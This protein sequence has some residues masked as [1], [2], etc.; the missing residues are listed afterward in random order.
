MDEK[1]RFTTSEGAALTIVETIVESEEVLVVGGDWLLAYG[2]A[3]QMEAK[4]DAAVKVAIGGDAAL[5]EAIGGSSIY[6]QNAASPVTAKAHV[7]SVEMT[8]TGGTIGDI[9]AGGY[10]V[11]WESAGSDASTSVGT[12]DIN[13]Q[14]AEVSGLYGAGSAISYLG[15]RAEVRADAV[16]ITLGD[17]A[18][19]DPKESYG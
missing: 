2:K 13:V 11:V 9:H 10:A 14:G 6:I 8:V 16:N 5:H 7:E 3:A 4:R 18:V 19:G 15:G 12:V 1:N 17:A